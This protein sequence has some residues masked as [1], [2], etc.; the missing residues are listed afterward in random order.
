MRVNIPE[1]S[2]DDVYTCVELVAESC[3]LIICWI[4]I[5]CLSMQL[6][7]STWGHVR[8]CSFLSFL[9]QH[10]QVL[11]TVLPCLILFRVL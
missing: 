10:K 1:K 2:Q 6:S 7:D 9:L 5:L 11:A 4:S 8:Y 3:I